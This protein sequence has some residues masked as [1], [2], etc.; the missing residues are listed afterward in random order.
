MRSRRSTVATRCSS[1]G[2]VV[3]GAVRA[4]AA[5]RR[6]GGLRRH[7]RRHALQ[8]G[9]EVHGQGRA[10]AQRGVGRLQ[11]G[12]EEGGRGLGAHGAA[13]GAH[14]GEGAPAD[15]EQAVVGERHGAEEG[16][17]D[18]LQVGDEALVRGVRDGASAS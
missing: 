10:R 9:G 15:G 2:R 14:G 8:H 6:E 12:E 5:R 18:P 16:D 11:R 7:A 1:S 17:A 13:D 3:V 4:V